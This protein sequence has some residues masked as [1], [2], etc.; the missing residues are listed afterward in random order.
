[1]AEQVPAKTESTELVKSTQATVPTFFTGLD[2]SKMPDKI[3]LFRC[4]QS[5]DKKAEN[6]VNVPFQIANYVLHPAEMVNRTDGELVELE[7]LVMITDK[8]ET[9]STA[10]A[11]IVRGLKMLVALFGN[12]PFNPPINV[13]IKQHP[14]K[15][16]NKFLT[17]ELAS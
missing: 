1:M 7:R 8:G 13:I 10:S 4:M 5:S 16:G 14:G 11:S 6:E 17:L 9:I 2:I 15:N 12:A 3:L